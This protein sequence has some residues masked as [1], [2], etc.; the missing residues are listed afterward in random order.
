VSARA[1]HGQ[2]EKDKTRRK[3]NERSV[4]RDSFQVSGPFLLATRCFEILL[5]YCGIKRRQSANDNDGESK[6]ERREKET[7]T[8][9]FS[10]CGVLRQSLHRRVLVGVLLDLLWLVGK[11]AKRVVEA[12]ADEVD[13]RPAGVLVLRSGRGNDA[14]DLEWARSEHEGRR[15]EKEKERT[16]DLKMLPE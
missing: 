8:H 5:L 1:W 9:P 10:R 12:G 6:Q 16:F 4:P 7:T 14:V 13:E 15:N 2:R 3:G 11:R